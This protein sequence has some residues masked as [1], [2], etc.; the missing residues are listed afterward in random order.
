MRYLHVQTTLKH[1][2]YEFL[3]TFTYTIK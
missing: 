3:F 1:M 2:T